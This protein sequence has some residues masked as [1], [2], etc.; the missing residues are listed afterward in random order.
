MDRFDGNAVRQL[1]LVDEGNAPIVRPSR[2]RPRP[3]LRL[4][5]KDIYTE[6]A[7]RRRQAQIRARHLIEDR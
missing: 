5:Q 1:I 6:L 3:S 2:E 4:L 7:R